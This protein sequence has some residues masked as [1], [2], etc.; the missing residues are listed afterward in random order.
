MQQQNPD[1]TT[2]PGPP[3][4]LPAQRVIVYIDGFRQHF[5]AKRIVIAFPPARSSARLM[6]A[7]HAA[8]TISRKTLKDSQLPE[9]VTKSDG[10]VLQRPQEWR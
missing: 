4:P 6:Q 8:F 1:S 10:F 5:P 2:R 7:A 3:A 9:Q